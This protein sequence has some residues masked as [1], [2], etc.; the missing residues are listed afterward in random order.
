MALSGR[1]ALA[2]TAGI[3]ALALMGGL[4]F[5]SQTEVSDPAINPL[6]NPNP[7]VI[8][9]WAKLPDGRTWGST[10]GIDIGPDGHVWAYD[11]CGSVDL[12]I[13]NCDGVPVAPV[14][15]FDRS[16][17]SVLASFGEGCSCFRTGSTWIAT[18]TSG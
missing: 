4:M 14:L 2:L 8:R 3:A 13:A 12:A 17:G 18:G 9:D 10:A 11:R 16:T 7:T 15:K 5:F 1:L 6:P